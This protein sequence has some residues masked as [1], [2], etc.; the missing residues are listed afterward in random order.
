MQTP[1]QFR[2]STAPG[3]VQERSLIEVQPPISMI[4]ADLMTRRGAWSCGRLHLRIKCE[5]SRISTC[6]CP[7]CQRRTRAII[8]N[9]AR[10]RREQVTNA[11][12]VSALTRICSGTGSWFLQARNPRSRTCGQQGRG[13]LRVAL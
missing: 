1:R 10:F 9:Q 6:H 3:V 2:G 5:P 13:E 8:S 7:E 12:N 4:G 11:G